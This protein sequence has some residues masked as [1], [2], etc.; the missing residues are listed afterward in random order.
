MV[1]VGKV[2]KGHHQEWSLWLN[3]HYISYLTSRP[4][5]FSIILFHFLRSLFS[6]S[7]TVTHTHTPTHSLREWGKSIGNGAGQNSNRM[8]IWVPKIKGAYFFSKNNHM[9]H[10]FSSLPKILGRNFCWLLWDFSLTLF[11]ILKIP[12]VFRFWRF[13]GQSWEILAI[14][15][16]FS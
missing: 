9:A 13:M 7:H 8:E 11:P 14:C 15:S 5:H 16:P 2:Q 12:S 3:S 4:L 10:T 6:H 1:Q